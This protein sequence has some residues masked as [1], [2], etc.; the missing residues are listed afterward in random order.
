MTIDF[1]VDPVAAPA[2]RGLGVSA[3]RLVHIYR[4]EGNDVVALTSVDLEVVPGETVALLG[5]S[6]SGKSTLLSLLAG[7]Y[8]PSAGRLRIGPHDVGALDDGELDRLRATS[9]ALVLQGARR[10]L[11]PYATPAQNVAFAQAAARRYGQD[12]SDPK[13]VLDLVGMADRADA[14]LRDLAPGQVQRVA[15]AVAIGPGPGLLLADEPTSQLDH[16]HR[17]EVMDALLDINRELGT[18]VVVVTHDAE[19]AAR[20]P[21][22]VTIR[23]GRIGSEGVGTE[24]LAV[25]GRDGSLQLPPHVIE[26][27]P[28]GSL[29]RVHHEADGRIVLEPVD[30]PEGE[31]R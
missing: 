14:A 13:A 31:P 24:E 22:R 5:P 19:V 8:P 15:V 29:L 30:S 10:N 18:T 2:P 17:D 20:I 6:G 12:V 16:Q 25:V 27:V 1:E 21:R 7:L 3:H 28:P 11:L 26:V 4:V 23:D 9:V